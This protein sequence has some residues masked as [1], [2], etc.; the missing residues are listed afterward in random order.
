[1]YIYFAAS[2]SLIES[3]LSRAHLLLRFQIK[4]VSH[5]SGKIRLFFSFIFSWHALIF[6]FTLHPIDLTTIP[7]C[8]VRFP[9]QFSTADVPLPNEAL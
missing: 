3:M 6:G 1:M 5:F 2:E 8:L 9:L 7:S 4:E